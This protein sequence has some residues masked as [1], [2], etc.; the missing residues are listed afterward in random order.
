MRKNNYT[1][2][3]ASVL[4]ICLTGAAHADVRIKMSQR[5]FMPGMPGPINTP[6][7]VKD[8]SQMPDTTVYIKGRRLRREV[9]AEKYTMTGPKKVVFTSLQQCDL[10][11]Q[12][13]FTSDKK[14][15]QV[16]Y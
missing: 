9:R 3:W 14:K 7:G 8:P 13:N 15:Y 5:K 1:L 6:A 10:G 16:T 12:V 2:I 4:V 11:R